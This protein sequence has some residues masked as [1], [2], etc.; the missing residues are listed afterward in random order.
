MADLISKKRE[1][2]KIRLPETWILLMVIIGMSVFF[3]SIKPVFFTFTNVINIIVSISVMLIIG[4]GMTMIILMA[5]IDVS[6]GG[7]LALSAVIC[8]SLLTKYEAPVVVAVVIALLVGTALGAFNGFCHVVLGIPILI[9]TLATLSVTRGLVLIFTKAQSTYGFPS[10]FNVIGQGKILGIPIPILITIVL[11]GVA[12][13]VLKF[14]SFGRSIYAIGNNPNAA[15]I[16]GIRVKIVKMIVFSITGFLCALAGITVIA[17]MDAAAAVLATGVEFRVIT[18]VVIGG[19]SIFGGRGSIGQTVIGVIIVGII[20]NGLQLLHVSVYY[21]QFIS[22]S[23]LLIA[24]SLDM[25]RQRGR[26]VA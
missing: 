6:V 13:F 10:S 1:K 8:G 26:L 12:I 14:T 22:G 18:A 17:R 16:S 7:I 24:V 20:I 9:V 5:G 2:L 21:S 11:V 15:K 3:G 25:L 23:I 4:I 19:T